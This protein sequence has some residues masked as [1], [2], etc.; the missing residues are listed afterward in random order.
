MAGQFK[1]IIIGA[2][3]KGAT[4]LV[5]HAKAFSEQPFHTVG[6]VDTAAEKAKGAAEKWGG[7]AFT[8]I[9]AAFERLGAVDVVTVATPDD[10]HEAILNQLIGK[11]AKLIFAEKPLC[12]SSDVAR[13]LLQTLHAY[14]QSVAVNYTRRFDRKFSD[15]KR[16]VPIW[17]N[18]LGGTAFY[19][20]GLHNL[21]HWVDLFLMAGVDPEAIHYVEID[22]SKLNV[23]DSLL[24]FEKGRLDVTKIGTEWRFTRACDR[25][26]FPE[27][28]LGDV[29]EG[30]IPDW[31][32]TPM[33]NAAA[34][35]ASHL[36]NGAP[37]LSPG[38]NAVKVLEICERILA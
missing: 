18:L 31:L 25:I 8:D 17:G 30:P 27:K 3:N 26:D 12:Q 34:N 19:T 32:K 2:G 35:I 6:F 37:L 7:E 9:N 1:V 29:T 5:S 28:I 36:Q 21:C 24:F 20:K 14:Q 38:E 13:H 11:P 23:F 4:G 16:F 22:R 33:Q 15:L 10:T